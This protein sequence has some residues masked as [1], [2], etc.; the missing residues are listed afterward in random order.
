MQAQLLTDNGSSSTACLGWLTLPLPL[1]FQLAFDC[2]PVMDFEDHFVVRLD[3]YHS[4]KNQP[5]NL[6]ALPSVQIGLGPMVAGFEVCMDM[7]ALVLATCVC[8]TTAPHQKEYHR[9]MQL[10]W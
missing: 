5:Q 7:L 10:T 8:A 2:A 4:V 9:Q 6:V 3:D 1:T